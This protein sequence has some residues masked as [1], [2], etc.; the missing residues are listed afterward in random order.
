MLRNYLK[1]AFRNLVRHKIYSYL[2]GTDIG[3][4]EIDTNPRLIIFA[5]AKGK[6]DDIHIQKLKTRFTDKRLI[7]KVDT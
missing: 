5:I 4:L 3:K 7:L 6:E 1:V 2:I